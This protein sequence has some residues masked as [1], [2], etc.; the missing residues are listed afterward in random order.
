MGMGVGQLSPHGQKKKILWGMVPTVDILNV[1]QNA[2]ANISL[3]LYLLF[4]GK[5][6]HFFVWD[7]D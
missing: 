1:A 4:T 5:K 7:Y 3:T 6:P 2:G